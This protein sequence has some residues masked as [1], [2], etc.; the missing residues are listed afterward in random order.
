[1][2]FNLLPSALLVTMLTVDKIGVAGWRFLAR[3]VPPQVAT[4]LVVWALL[5]FPV[6]LESRMA[7]IVASLPLMLSYPLALSTVTYALGH[8]VAR[9]NRQ[10]ARLDRIYVQTGLPNSLPWEQV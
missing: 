9:Q 10:L 3:T 7:N 1:M 6:R 8:R 4:C 2:Q 5:G